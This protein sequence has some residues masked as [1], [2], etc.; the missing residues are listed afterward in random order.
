[1]FRIDGEC[2]PIAVAGRCDGPEQEG[3]E[4]RTMQHGHPEALATIRDAAR[5]PQSPADGGGEGMEPL[6]PELRGLFDAYAAGKTDFHALHAA[7][8]LPVKTL[9]EA[10]RTIA[11]SLS[12]DAIA[13]FH[14]D[15]VTETVIE[16]YAAGKMDIETASSLCHM[17]EADIRS[18]LDV[19]HLPQAEARRE[20][21]AAAVRD[22]PAIPRLVAGLRER[23]PGCLRIWLAGERA[24]GMPNDEAAYEL[25][26]VGPDAP[27]GERVFLL[28]GNLADSGMYRLTGKCV[29]LEVRAF[30]KTNF[31]TLANDGGYCR[32]VAREGVLLYGGA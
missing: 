27:D 10:F 30:N 11:S 20:L 17:G 2:R 12:A 16:E 32:R 13:R 15:C 5:P 9:R 25:L 21:A 31:E 8:G 1:M 29:S 7:S 26:A 22:D 14:R 6:T 23:L 18:A 4:G 3:K 28:N 19:R 24:W